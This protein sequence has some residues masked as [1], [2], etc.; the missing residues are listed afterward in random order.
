[1]MPKLCHIQGKKAQ[2]L[3][4]NWPGV[5]G[6]VWVNYIVNFL[7]ETFDNGYSIEP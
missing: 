2:E 5:S 1:M 3:I 7:F 4:P 6:L